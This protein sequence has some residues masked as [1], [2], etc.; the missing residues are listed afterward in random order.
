[1]DVACSTYEETG[2]VYW[3]LARTREAMRPLG[4]PSYRWENNIKT[5]LNEVGCEDMDKL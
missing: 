4:R 2:D 5:E 1:M 3:V